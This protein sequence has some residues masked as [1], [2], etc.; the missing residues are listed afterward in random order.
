MVEDKSTFVN[1]MDNVEHVNAKS[2]LIDFHI[3][4]IVRPLSEWLSRHE[5]VYYP[6]T[7]PALINMARILAE[8]R[9]KE[10]ELQILP[11]G[12]IRL[13]SEELSKNEQIAALRGVEISHNQIAAIFLLA[14]KYGFDFSHYRFDGVPKKYSV[15]DV[16]FLIHM[17]D[18]GTIE[19]SGN[20]GLTDGQLKEILLST[21]FAVARIL[22]NGRHWHCFYQTNRGLEGKES[23]EYGH[24]PH[25]HY[26]SD[27]FGVS[28]EQFVSFFKNG[29]I[30]SSKVHIPLTD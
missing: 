19:H 6:C 10:S 23:G 24:R 29:N 20:T 2:C 7:S 12:I 16:P 4:S 27:S 28:R 30:I 1:I 13:F 26:I 21:K 9:I 11:E 8:D 17:I 22:D 14:A 5:G 25:V 15:D 3:K 18:D